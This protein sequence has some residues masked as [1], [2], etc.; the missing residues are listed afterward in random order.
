MQKSRGGK[1]KVIIDI[2]TLLTFY[3]SLTLQNLRQVSYEWLNVAFL[4]LLLL[5]GKA[6]IDKTPHPAEFLYAILPMSDIETHSSVRSMISR[7]TA[8]CP[9]L[10]STS[11]R[12]LGGNKHRRKISVHKFIHYKNVNRSVLEQNQLIW[13]T[14]QQFCFCLVSMGT[15]DHELNPHLIWFSVI[16]DLGKFQCFILKKVGKWK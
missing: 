2:A 15:S 3:F 9:T 6:H 11:L 10:S 13:M 5:C 8:K 4:G 7:T 16:M 1:L 14:F 12:A